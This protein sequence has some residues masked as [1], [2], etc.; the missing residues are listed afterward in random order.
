M[1]ANTELTLRARKIA[2][3]LAAAFGGRSQYNAT[4]LGRAVGGH[5][6]N[7]GFGYFGSIPELCKAVY[8]ESLWEDE[9]P[10]YEWW[11]PD[12]VA[13]ATTYLDQLRSRH[14]D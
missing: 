10:D 11:I 1:T 8:E 13:A 2:S 6:N 4:D 3:A 14:K 9:T 12:A 7:N 5:I